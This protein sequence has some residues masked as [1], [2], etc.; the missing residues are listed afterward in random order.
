MPKKIVSFRTWLEETDHEVSQIARLLKVSR[1]AIYQWRDGVT[2]PNF[3]NLCA[4]ID[5]SAGQLTPRSFAENTEPPG[6][7]VSNEGSSIT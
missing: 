3:D 5:L 1:S 6:A 4:L 7:E 2:K